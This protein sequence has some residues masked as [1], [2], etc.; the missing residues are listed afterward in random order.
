MLCYYLRGRQVSVLLLLRLLST[1]GG[2][3][4]TCFRVGCRSARSSGQAM[5]AR[6]AVRDLD[7]PNNSVTMGWEQRACA[8]LFLSL[9]RAINALYCPT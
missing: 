7:L 3:S 6:N 1:V 5:E 4:L 9:A 8:C 2:S